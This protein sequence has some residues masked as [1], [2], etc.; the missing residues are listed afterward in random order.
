MSVPTEKILPIP[1]SF[2]FTE[3]EIRL[4]SLWERTPPKTFIAV[5]HTSICIQTRLSL[6]L[7]LSL[8]YTYTH[9]LFFVRANESW[10]NIPFYLSF[11]YF[12][13]LLFCIASFPPTLL[14][15]IIS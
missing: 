8:S 3:V 1:R 7:S 6:S 2:V 9:T 5:L 4:P 12:V 15:S 10:K 13:C 11:V 14:P